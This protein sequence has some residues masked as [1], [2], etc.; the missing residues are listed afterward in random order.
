[1]VGFLEL[2]FRQA[3]N[4]SHNK[5]EQEDIHVYARTCIQ[6]SILLFVLR[7]SPG[8]IHMNFIEFT[9]DL[10]FGCNTLLLHNLQ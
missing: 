6:T 2:G 3:Q 5:G 8:M 7:K 10:I 1:M 9:A 4:A